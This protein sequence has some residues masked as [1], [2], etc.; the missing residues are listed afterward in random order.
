[1]IKPAFKK[2]GHFPG[3]LL[4]KFLTRTNNEY[5]RFSVHDK[6]TLSQVIEP[7]DVLLVEGNQYVSGAIKYL[8]QSTW[9]HA[10]I[11]VGN[12]IKPDENPDNPLTL[13]EAD[14]KN[15]VIGVPLS[16]YDNFNTRIC[17]PVNLTDEDKAHVI[18]YII[19]HL[20]DAY[21]TRNIVDLAR[22]LLPTP[23]IPARFRRRMISL[24]SGDPTRAICSS[25]IAQAFQSVRYPIIPTTWPKDKN[26][27]RTIY[28]IRHHSLFT[29]SDF[30][31]S[32]YFEVVKPTLSTGFDYKSLEWADNTQEF[33]RVKGELLADE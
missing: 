28:N 18:D 24:G 17:R 2:I 23:P 15:G 19:Q 25:L 26:D 14:I 29:P 32:P 22:Y 5:V 8:T 4:V 12:I 6:K 20:G 30:D 10:A 21:D 11:Y 9:S 1:M 7:G 3:K 16:K 33:M 27:A 13:V 31:L